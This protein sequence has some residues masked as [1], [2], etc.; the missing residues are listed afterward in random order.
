MITL[1]QSVT[2]ETPQETTYQGRRLDAN[3][4]SYLPS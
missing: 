1:L 2:V 3:K 4:V